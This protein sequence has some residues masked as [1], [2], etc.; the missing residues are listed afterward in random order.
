MAIQTILVGIDFSPEST[1]ALK[2][3]LQ[4][5]T[6]VGA[7]LHLVHA[8]FRP[9]IPASL[10]ALPK[11]ADA[12]HK[13][14]A[15]LSSR[16]GEKLQALCAEHSTS[17]LR[18]QSA[19]GH[20]D[21]AQVVMDAATQVNA[22]M[23]VV[24]THGRTGFRRLRL[25]SVAESVAQQAAC[26]VLVSR[27][28]SSDSTGFEQVLVPTDFSEPSEKAL[29]MATQIVAPDGTIRLL[30]AWINPFEVQALYAGSEQAGQYHEFI[31]A[32]VHDQ[33][34]AL[35]QKM[36]EQHSSIVFEQTQGN[37][38]EI[39]LDAMSNHATDLIVMGASRHHLGGVPRATIR[40]ADCSVMVVR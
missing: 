2:Q 16:A 35:A 3:A 32:S 14:D 1:Q 6:R 26:S 8:L 10:A 12:G 15:E 4:L 22:D 33:G 25:G 9:S 37:A 34:N 19:V 40:H 31:E 30:H 27:A 39:I 13:L 38:T 29:A 28:D 7:E 24:G 21:A 23:I 20:G 5:A 36:R 17:S 18:M 11:L